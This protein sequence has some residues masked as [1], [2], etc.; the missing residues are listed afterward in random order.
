M[1][2]APHACS[3][4]EISKSNVVDD[5]VASNATLFKGDEHPDHTVV[6]KYM[7]FVGD[8][9]RAL[10][11]YVSEIFLGGINTIAMHNTCEDSLL[12]APLI[13]DLIII[14]EL[15]ER[16]RVQRV[17]VDEAPVRFHSVLSLLSYLCKAPLVPA[18][19]PVINALFK[20][21]E[22][23]VNVF[24][25]CVGLAPE[26]HMLMEHR[27][28]APTGVAH[29]AAAVHVTTASPVTASA[30]VSE[31]ETDSVAVSPSPRTMKTKTVVTAD[32]LAAPA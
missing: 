4:K 30:S 5:M 12:A 32:E 2:P 13:M 25:A 1:F 21:R 29:A 27:L 3:S 6:I 14:T 11:E 19:A 18:G 9:K 31:D 17:G 10:D 23:L 16:I 28:P 7:P 20:Q 24:R 15:C 8:S 26:N 22:A